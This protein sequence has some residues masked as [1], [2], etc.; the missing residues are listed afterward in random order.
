MT[1]EML[2][3]S[4]VLVLE[5]QNI[6]LVERTKASEP[7]YYVLPGG[8]IE[9]G[10]T[11]EQAAIREMKEELGVDI[12]VQSAELDSSA[13]DRTTWIVRATIPGDQTPAWREY[14]KQ[15]P[16]NRYRVVWLPVDDL[17]TL[18]IYPSYHAIQSRQ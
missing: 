16:G 10:E 6:L 15:L 3:R 8:G 4:A 2:A 1:K 12:A 13:T 11:P 9:A 17:A 5:G 7:V 18:R 14:H